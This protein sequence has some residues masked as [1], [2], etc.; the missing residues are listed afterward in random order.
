M[1]EIPFRNVYFTS[2]IRDEQG[3]KALE[4][5][6]QFADPLDVIAEY[7]ADALRFTITYIAPVAWTSATA[8]E[9]CET[10]DLRDKLW[11]AGRFRR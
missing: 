1:K 10:A 11:N 6:R 9:K 7:G 2:I 5:A 3:R 4:V 8:M